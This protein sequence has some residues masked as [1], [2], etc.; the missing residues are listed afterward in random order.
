MDRSEERSKTARARRPV[1]VTTKQSRI[2]VCAALIVSYHDWI[3]ESERP[4]SN[5]VRSRRLAHGWSQAELAERAG[6]S[7]TAISAIEVQR[8]VPSVNAALALARELGCTVEELF[9]SSEISTVSHWAWSPPHPEWRYWRAEVRGRLMLYPVDMSGPTSGLPH[10]A[11][12]DDTS[13]TSEQG[14][15]AARTLVVACCDPAVGLLSNV[16]N[17]RTGFRLIAIPRSSRASLDLLAEGLVHVAGL[18]LSTE[19]K[20]ENARVVKEHLASTHR[21]LRVANWQEGLAVTRAEHSHSVRTIV[22]SK[23]RWVGREPGSAARQCMDELLDGRT[24]PRR[25][26]R[27]HRGVAEAIHAGWADVG[28]CLRLTCEEAGLNFLSLREEI[29]EF[30]FPATSEADPRIQALLRV[31]RSDEYRR[32]LMDLPGYALLDSGELRSV[33]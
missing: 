32:L 33:S 30:C 25:I 4:L 2:N 8:L 20:D 1:G 13:M 27:G 26:A 12:G 16:Y 28:V 19:S 9:G 15:L 21:L 23:L 6:I 18:H 29:F 11:R 17:R 3:M 31:V 14:Q 22:G 24:S 5:R 10:D 7:R